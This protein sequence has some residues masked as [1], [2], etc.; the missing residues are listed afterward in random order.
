M[1]ALTPII[2]I[3]VSIGLFFFQIMPLYSDV[4]ILRTE[5]KQLNEALKV[6]EELKKLRGELADRLASF[7]PEELSE[8]ER[9]MPPRLDS[10]RMINDVNGIADSNDIIL[11]DIKTS[12]SGQSAGSASASAP[13][14]V[15]AMS[16]AFSSSYAAALDF[17]KELEKSLRLIDVVSLAIKSSEKGGGNY[18]FNITLNTYWVGKR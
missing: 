11:R 15:T 7:T 9:F 5:E 13:Y 17:I 6:A 2:L 12:D 3:L 1:K 8:L 10:V 14:N 4:K 16:F 18:D